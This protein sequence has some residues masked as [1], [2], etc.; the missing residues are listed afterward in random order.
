M[1]NPNLQRNMSYYMNC[2]NKNASYMSYYSYDKS[3]VE[4]VCLGFL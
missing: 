1:F 4:V 3:K 2:I